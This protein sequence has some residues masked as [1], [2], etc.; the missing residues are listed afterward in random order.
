MKRT[1]LAGVAAA[2]LAS[3][4]A[5]PSGAQ[6][7]PQT[8][9]TVD[10][11]FVAVGLRISKV[12]GATVRGEDNAA[13]GRIDDLIVTP[14]ERVPFAVL[15]VGG[16]LGMNR[17]LVIVPYSALQMRDRKIVLPGAT[18]AMLRALPEFRYVS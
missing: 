7:V 2:F 3:L 10:L 1:V 8:M 13:I 4:P 9:A 17:K 6:G 18:K 5:G 11:Q 12:V 15:S 14:S 16:F